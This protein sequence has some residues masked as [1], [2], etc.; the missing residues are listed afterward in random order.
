MQR[1]VS[2]HAEELHCQFLSIQRPKLIE[3]NRIL[4]ELSAK[5]AAHEDPCMLQCILG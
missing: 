4:Q 1:S 3:E 5:V 2:E